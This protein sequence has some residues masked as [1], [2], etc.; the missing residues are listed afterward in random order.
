MHEELMHKWL[1]AWMRKRMNEW[2][3][4]EWMHDMMNVQM[5]ECMTWWMYKWVNAWKRELGNECMIE[6][7]HEF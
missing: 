3:H 4:D 2:M 6:C 1:N 7:M 5:S